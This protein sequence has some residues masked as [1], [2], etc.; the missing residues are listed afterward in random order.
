MKAAS[1]TVV[2]DVRT[3]DL[4]VTEKPTIAQ[5]VP[6]KLVAQHVPTL[7][8]LVHRVATVQK[9]I[10]RFIMSLRVVA[11]RNVTLQAKR[12]IV[13]N[14]ARALKQVCVPGQ[15]KRVIQYPMSRVTRLSRGAVPVRGHLWLGV[16]V[17]TKDS[18]SNWSRQ[19]AS[20]AT[21]RTFSPQGRWSFLL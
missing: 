13:A 6:K 14:F 10:Y 12:A 15:M 2:A 3:V 19:Q 9:L 20:H 17:C 7:Q 1:A 21:F 5:Q 18:L 11:H 4:L 16:R 8:I